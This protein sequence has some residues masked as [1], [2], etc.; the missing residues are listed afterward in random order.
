MTST[1]DSSMVDTIE[2]YF[3]EVDRFDTDAILAHLADDCFMEI[4][5]HGEAYSG[6]AEIRAVY[7]ARAER[8]RKSWHGDFQHTVDAEA[9][10]VATRLTVR[11]T[12]SD[13]IEETI[14]NITVFEIANRGIRRISVWMNGQNT[15]SD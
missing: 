1:S 10:R 7:D 2:A 9:G 14:D 13:G 11:R 8:V 6:L 4:V 12:L 3:H 5:T 15:L